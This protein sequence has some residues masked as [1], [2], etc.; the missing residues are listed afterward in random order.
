MFCSSCGKQI[1]DGARFCEFCGAT[2]NATIQP[3][4]HSKSSQSKYSQQEQTNILG[5]AI[6]LETAIEF[7]KREAKNLSAQTFKLAPGKPILPKAPLEPEEP[8][9]PHIDEP[10]YVK[11][12]LPKDTVPSFSFWAYEHSKINKFLFIHKCVWGNLLVATSFLV[13]ALLVGFINL[14]IAYDALIVA[15]VIFSIYFIIGFYPFVVILLKSFK[16]KSNLEQ[17]KADYIESAEYKQAVAEAYQAADN[18]NKI[19]KCNYEAQLKANQ[20]KYDAELASRRSAYANAMKAYRAN[21]DKYN[22][23]YS[24]WENETQAWKKEKESWMY[25]QQ[26]KSSIVEKDLSENI[27]A[28]ETLY[29]STQLIP[30][31]YRTLERMYWLY[32]DMSTSEHD[33]ER[34]IDLLNTKEIKEELMQIQNKVNDVRSV[35]EVGFTAVYSA[36]QDGNLLQNE[37]LNSQEEIIANQ[38]S[39]LIQQS[40]ILS[41]LNKIR[42]SA[43]TNNFL[44]VGQVLQNLKSN[45]LLT[46]IQ[47]NTM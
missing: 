22:K 45:R 19:I 25:T 37:I 29:T 16:Y 15:V 32:E 40:D 43:R 47:K 35:V 33:I 24:E 28:L 34:A 7:E 44:N 9:L 11:P 39:M 1:N 13:T 14:F 12:I 10:Q 27:S 3:D 20:E 36:I 23:L 2:Q 21:M 18:K 17:I 46:Q 4:N 6:E 30:S 38:Y 41:D 5:M 42:K 8:I 31:T 26:I